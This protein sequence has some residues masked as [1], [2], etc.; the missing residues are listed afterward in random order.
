MTTRAARVHLAVLALLVSGLLPS[1]AAAHA[2]LDR[3]DPAPGVVLPDDR[4]PSRLI[5][6]FTEP[7]TVGPNAIVVLDGQQRRVGPVTAR[8]AGST[9][10]EVETPPLAPG[11]YAVRWRVTSA[12]SHVVRGTYWFAVGWTS[13]PPPLVSLLGTGAPTVPWLEV[14]ARWLALV[15]TL[16]LAGIALFDVIVLRP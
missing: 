2:L 13:T 9:R 1:S 7:V 16:G 8:V 14:L 5:L 10:V 6:Q 11:P 3:A 12:D 15:A 4:P